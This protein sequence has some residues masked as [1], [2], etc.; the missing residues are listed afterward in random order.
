MSITGFISSAHVNIPV[1]PTTGNTEAVVVYEENLNQKY[2]AE[3]YNNI[4]IVLSQ[5]WSV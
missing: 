5:W 3:I 2:F 4:V 1:V